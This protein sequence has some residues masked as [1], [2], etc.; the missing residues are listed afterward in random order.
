MGIH[1]FGVEVVDVGV[2]RFAEVIRAGKM[3]GLRYLKFVAYQSLSLEGGGVLGEA[4]THADASLNFLEEV[5]LLYQIDAVTAAFLE[6]LSRGT[7]RLPA[8]HTLHCTHGRTIG[9]DGAQSLSALVS[10]GRV[11]S[12]KDL[13]VRLGGIGQEGMQP[14]AASLNSP[15]VF[16]LRKLFVEIGQVAPANAAVE[17]GLFSAAFSSGHLCRLEELCVGGLCV[18][19]EVR[20]LC[21]GLGSGGLSSLRTLQLSACRLGVEGGRALSEVVVA[22]KLPS[23]RI[24]EAER[25]GLA[26]EGVRALVEVWMTRDPPPLQHLGFSNTALTIGVVNPLLQFLGSQRLHAPETVS[27]SDNWSIDQASKDSLLGA[28]PEAV[29]F[30]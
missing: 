14:F 29:K 23:L 4:L 30:C 28:F 8:L 27:L 5:L 2:I 22:E 25:T 26:D 11:P 16:A 3:S 7:G 15:H 10:G 19:E 1:S 18:I 13:K 17:V 9:T 12:L 21:V 20:A 24:L 6:G